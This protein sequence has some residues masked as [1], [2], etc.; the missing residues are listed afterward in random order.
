MESEEGNMA[1]YRRKTET[2][3][4]DLNVPTGASS[5]GRLLGEAGTDWTRIGLD[6]LIRA[7]IVALAT[8]IFWRRGDLATSSPFVLAAVACIYAVLVLFPLRHCRDSIQFHENG[9]VY[10]GKSY[11]FQKPRAEWSRVSGTGHFLSVTY[12]YL[13]GMSNGINVSCVRDAQKIFTRLYVSGAERL[14]I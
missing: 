4:Y 5:L 10:R 13:D 1:R 12:L 14:E 8:F 11:L 3:T 7:A 9:I 2:T 6:V